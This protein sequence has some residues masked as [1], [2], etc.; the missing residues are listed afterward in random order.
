[1][2]D[3]RKETDFELIVQR[4]KSLIYSICY[5]FSPDKAEADDL[6]QEVL[7]RLWQGINTFRAESAESTWVYRISLNTCISYQR[8]QKKRK[9]ATHVQ[10]DPEF[11]EEE[12][13]AN[14]QMSQLRTRIQ[15]LPPLDRA[16]VLM[17]LENLPYDEI[18][19]IAGISAKAVGVRLVRIRERLKH[20]N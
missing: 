2:R 16:I 7:I 3:K 11:F 6:F 9:E 8:K 20:S 4:N 17:W 15:N 14:P 12:E 5:M 10:I 19:A 13:K 18:G 1:M